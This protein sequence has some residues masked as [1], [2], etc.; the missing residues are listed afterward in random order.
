MVNHV[1]NVVIVGGGTAGW[2][3]ASLL[4]RI[5]KNHIQITLIESDE[6]GTVG[7]GEASIPPMV[8]FNHALGIG[9]Q[10]FI[11][12]TK[13]T[14]KLGIEFEGWGDPSNN[15]MHAFGELGKSFP[16]C[17]FSHIWLRAH[18][19]GLSE[20]ISEFSLNTQ[21]AK[22]SKFA[23]LKTIP[24][25]QLTGLTYAYHFDAGLY[26]QLLSEHSQAQGVKRVEGKVVKVNSCH[27]S[28][29]ITS[30]E[31][32]SG[33][34]HNA[35]FFI[36]CSGLKGLLIEQTL[37]VGFEDWAHWL[38][39]DS[40]WAVP[41]EHS[42]QEILPYTKSMAQTAG[43][44]WQIPLQHRVGNGYVFS[45]KFIDEQTAKNNLLEQLPAKPISEP[46]LIKFK[47]GM[48]RKQWHQNVFAIGLSSGFLEPLES[49]SIHLIQTAALRLI[50]H[51]PYEGISQAA[52]D[53]ANAEFEQ[54]MVQV[55]DFIIL[56][57]KLTQRTDTEFWRWCKRMEVPESV[58]KKI[59]LFSET[60]SCPVK[61][62]ELFQSVAWQQVMLGQGI[63]PKGY[64]PLAEQ[65]DEA[66]LKSLLESLKTLIETTVD[67]LPS[68]S[69][70]VNKVV[71]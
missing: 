29:N 41:C 55:R 54:E 49:T 60:G 45:S 4:K 23:H 9:E 2:I 19:L 22:S 40:A 44:Q 66:Q 21:A 7:V 53:A 10:E 1:K 13:A 52:V 39:C 17:D 50:K 28:G 16:F 65:L 70:F 48:R 18:K 61:T 31:L 63:M 24:N 68:H 8:N 64:H 47:T 26:A 36:D 38:P 32:H 35:D 34:Q 71:S 57:Y 51:F 5:L 12:K 27:M 58:S 3:T 67:K 42:A 46:K 15:Y 25:T 43:W 33:H 20:A 56:H 14:Y 59:A 69:V 6:I 62:E 37:N 11:K 30:V